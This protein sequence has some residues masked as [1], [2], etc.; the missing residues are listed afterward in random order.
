[1][2]QLHSQ[3]ESLKNFSSDILQ[4]NGHPAPPTLQTQKLFGFVFSCPVD[5]HA[6]PSSN[7]M[8]HAVPSESALP[9]LHR[10]ASAH[11][12]SPSAQ[13]N[14]QSPHTLTYLQH[15]DSLI[16]TINHILKNEEALSRCQGA[17][18]MTKRSTNCGESS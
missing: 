11:P 14:T 15:Y 12:A 2:T 1:M 4:Q 18:N 5:G 7:Q 17:M 6:R 16:W 3:V 13:R 8:L 10:G 9:S